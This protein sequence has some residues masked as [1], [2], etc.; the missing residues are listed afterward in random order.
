MSAAQ[1]PRWAVYVG[2]IG[3]PV[4]A[5]LAVLF[6]NWITRRGQKETEGRSKREEV[7]RNLRW[8][9]DLAVCQ[10]QSTQPER[11]GWGA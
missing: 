3:S 7:M 2:S 10:R 1:L 4:A 9:A 11:T 6:G 5:F 8:A